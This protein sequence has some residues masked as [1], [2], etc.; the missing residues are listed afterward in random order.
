MNDKMSVSRNFRIGDLYV[1]NVAINLWKTSSK[2]ERP[3][4]SNFSER[5]IH[6]P[7][8]T[9]FM[10][11]AHPEVSIRAMAFTELRVLAIVK[12]IIVTGYVEINYNIYKRSSYIDLISSL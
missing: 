5:F 2:E 4:G 7:V 10:T 6:L 8:G 12:G 1:L 9:Y 11:L 3:F